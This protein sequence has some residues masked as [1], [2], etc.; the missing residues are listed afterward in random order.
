MG[1]YVYMLKCADGRYYVGST[2]TSLERRI[3]EHQSG[4]FGGF[5]AAR[6]PV[7]LV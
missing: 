6:L 4:C 5:T 7:E 2:R 3:A 1:A